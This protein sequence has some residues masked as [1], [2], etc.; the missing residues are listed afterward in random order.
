M[1]DVSHSRMTSVYLFF[2]FLART[3][4]WYYTSVFVRKFRA[5]YFLYKFRARATVLLLHIFFVTLYMPTEEFVNF[6]LASE[7]HICASFTFSETC[8]HLVQATC[9]AHDWG[10]DAGAHHTTTPK[11]ATTHS[12]YYATR[13]WRMPPPSSLGD[14]TIKIC[15][16][17]DGDYGEGRASSSRRWR[18]R[19]RASASMCCRLPSPSPD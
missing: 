2:F 4:V 6:I 19:G 14:K 1:S 11:K 9:V 10:I 7:W 12:H 5:H 15:H 8:T 3:L 17:D 13:P 16:K 18:R